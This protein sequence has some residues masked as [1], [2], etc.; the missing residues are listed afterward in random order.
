MDTTITVHTLMDLQG[1]QGLIIP[2]L[3]TRECMTIPV[4]FLRAN[5]AEM[6][7]SCQVLTHLFPYTTCILDIE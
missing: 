5:H 3:L 6:K 4:Y 7:H 1:L 2:E